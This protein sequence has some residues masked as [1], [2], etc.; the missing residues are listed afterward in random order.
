MPLFLRKSLRAGPLR[1]NLS[2]SGIGVSTGVPGLRV[3]L[4][5]PRGHY[6]YMGRDGLYYRKTLGKGDHRSTVSPPPQDLQPAPQDL[7]NVSEPVLE[8]T[9]G[10]T[11]LEMAATAPGEL[12]SQL[13]AS[14]KTAAVW[15]LAAIGAAALTVACLIAVFPWG[16]LIAIPAAAGAWWI[17]QWDTARRAVVVFFDVNDEYAQ[18]Y[19]ALIKGFESVQR[20][21]RTFRVVAAGSTDADEKKHQAGADTI[22]PPQDD[23]RRC[24][25][26]HVR[27]LSPSA[28]RGSLRS[29]R[30]RALQDRERQDQGVLGVHQ[31]LTR[32]RRILQIAGCGSDCHI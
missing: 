29:R 11:V 30:S 7:A 14:E 5:G 24:L 3:G 31:G 27:S 26:V 8:D 23:G 15:V 4:I 10:A 17:R 21:I 16:G 20:S 28:G 25:R 13:S 9:T 32:I 22:R 19:E 18:R 1:F 6:V 12:V 2:R